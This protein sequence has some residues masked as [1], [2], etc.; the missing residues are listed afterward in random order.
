MGSRYYI[1]S[2]MALQREIVID[3]TDYFSLVMLIKLHLF[4]IPPTY[5]LLVLFHAISFTRYFA[6]SVTTEKKSK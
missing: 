1:C 2:F 3:I 4:F 6:F 5:C